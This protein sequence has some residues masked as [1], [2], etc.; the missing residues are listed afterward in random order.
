MKPSHMTSDAGAWRT[1]LKTHRV[2]IGLFLVGAALRLVLLCYVSPNA[3]I[4][5]DEMLYANLARAIHLGQPFNVHGQPVSFHALLYPLL[6]SPVYAL[7]TAANRQLVLQVLNTLL[8]A[9]AGRPALARAR[10]R[11]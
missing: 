3:I 6:I 9:S 1:A 4:V 2:L 5:P 7:P 8:M 10:R 11:G